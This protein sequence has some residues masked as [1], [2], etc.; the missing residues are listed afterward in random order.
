MISFSS[1]LVHISYLSIH[2]ANSN[3]KD[4]QKKI[5]DDS[6]S[7]ITSAG[8]LQP[9]TRNSDYYAADSC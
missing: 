2:W 7:S 8:R 9:T 6:Y 1:P 5:P 4:D 3:S